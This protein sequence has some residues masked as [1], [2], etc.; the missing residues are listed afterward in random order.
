[1]DLCLSYLRIK[2]AES[3][4]RVVQGHIT[5]ITHSTQLLKCVLLGQ[6]TVIAGRVEGRIGEGLPGT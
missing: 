4:V 3:A 1:M 2:G 6:A 5:D